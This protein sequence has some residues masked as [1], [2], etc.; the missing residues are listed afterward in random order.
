M[1][2]FSFTVTEDEALERIDKTISDLYEDFSRSYIQKLISDK[3]VFVN[4]KNV[5]G[6]YILKEKD[7]VEFTTPDSIIPD[8]IPEDIKIDIIYEDDDVIVLN[9]PK[10]MVVHPAPGHYTGTLVNGLMNYLK[11]GDSY[12]L[13]GINGV[14]RP[15]IVHR[16]DKDT[17]GSLIVCKN[18]NAHEKIAV[19]LKE[20]SINRIYE[21]VVHGVLKADEGVINF[22]I[23]RSDKDRKKMA[24]N[25]K[26]SKTAVTH[27]KVLERFDKYTHVE[28]KLE[29]G[30]TH[31]IRVHMAAIGHPVLGDEIYCTLKCPFKLQGQTLHART[32][33]FIQPTTG[34]YIETNAPLPEYFIEL[35]RKL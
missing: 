31:Q 27:Y 1:R 32:L 35:L 4:G 9:K 2:F 30:R 21:A 10:N 12:K 20:H 8:I 26:N 22:P 33:G 28:L 5:K 17:T 3:L 6:S 19:Q 23:G 13:S 25:A 18:N 24:I 29:T 15:G 16:I 34:E 7:F 11:D 14:L